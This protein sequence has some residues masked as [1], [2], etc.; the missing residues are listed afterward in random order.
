MPPSIPR[1]DGLSRQDLTSLIEV[2]MVGQKEKHLE[3]MSQQVL[4]LP[5]A[6]VLTIWL[7]MARLEEA[8]R[9]AKIDRTQAFYILTHPWWP[10]VAEALGVP[11]TC[12][13]V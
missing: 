2:L 13:P 5:A 3:H 11:T 12:N 9:L 7:D 4:A 1:P 10:K 8:L 6:D